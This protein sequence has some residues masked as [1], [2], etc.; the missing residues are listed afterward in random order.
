MLQI[1]QTKYYKFKSDISQPYPIYLG[2]NKN[3]H[4]N[5]TKLENID[6]ARW[7]IYSDYQLLLNEIT[8]TVFYV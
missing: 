7:E 1:F 3:F 5:C 2:W 8:L 6:G 4:I